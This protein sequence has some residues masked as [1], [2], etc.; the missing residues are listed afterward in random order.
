MSQRIENPFDFKY[1]QDKKTIFEFY[2]K[3]MLTR[4]QSMFV[5]EN[6]PDS[7]PVQWLEY[8][9]QTYGSCCIAEVKGKLYALIGSAGGELDAYYQPTIY[10]VANPALD[11]STTYT[12]GTDCVYCRN[13]F[14][15][16]GLVPLLSRYCG[17]MTENVLTIR[18]SD[19]SMRNMFLLSAPDDNTFQSTKQF[20]Q[21]LEE[22][23]LGAIA[24]NPFF[25][26]IKMQS[27]SHGTGDY[28]IQFIE[29]QQ[30]LKGSLYN[31]LGLNANFNMKREA[32]SGD[33]IA[34]NDD[35]LMPLID[36]ML[37]QRRQMCSDLKDMFG[38]DV[39]VDYGSTWHSN[40]VEKQVVADSEFAA[41]PDEAEEM[42]GDE[43]NLP[44]D[45]SAQDVSQ[46]NEAT[47]NEGE[48]NEDPEQ[49]EKPDN[50]EAE[51]EQE[52][53]TEDKETDE[54]DSESKDNDLRKEVD[55][56]SASDSDNSDD[57][58]QEE[59]PADDSESEEPESKEEDQ[60]SEKS[61]ES[62]DEQTA[63][64]SD[65]DKKKKEKKDDEDN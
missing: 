49:Q 52:K 11:L 32:L 59:K 10:T 47:D 56:E 35:A 6:L 46:L 29:L 43:S 39:S 42:A 27:S 12:I 64:E 16:V 4:T 50:P 26:G 17:L 41:D 5:Y 19:I 54:G 30:Y 53:G 58:P 24:D 48:V 2:C 44:D 14:T 57:K 13:D 65:E 9:L 60:P 62:S 34:M 37:K 31:E 61:D 21:D 55:D 20:L 45:D 1:F 36:D 18:Q 25:D 40:V 7:I 8:Y 63:E 22:G 38:I 23:K 3:Y 33:E 28:M 51:D 15:A